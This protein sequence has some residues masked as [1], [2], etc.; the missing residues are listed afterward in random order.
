MPRKSGLACTI[1]EIYSERPLF[2]NPRAKI[3][4][5]IMTREE[6]RAFKAM[7][8]S[9]LKFRP[10]ERAAT[11]QVLQSEWMIGWGIPALY[12]GQSSFNPMP[13]TN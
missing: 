10:E 8:L 1:F 13:K 12:E 6:D 11:E 5:E 9:M 3:D 4:L 2:E 7:L